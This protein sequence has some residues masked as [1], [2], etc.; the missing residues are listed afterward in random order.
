MAKSGEETFI[1][2]AVKAIVD[3]P[4]D[5]IIERSV[6]DL[7]VLLAL[8]VHPDDMGKVIGAGGQ[9]ATALRKLLAI[10]GARQN[11]R[12]NLKI[13]EPASGGGDKS[14]KTD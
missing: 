6:D 11:T 9:T 3:R 14:P 13:S 12:V 1:A 5:V 8:S 7:G 4:N 10:F 2:Y